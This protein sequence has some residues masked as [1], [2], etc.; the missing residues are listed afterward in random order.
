MIVMGFLEPVFARIPG[1]AFADA[2]RSL[3]ARR[4]G[5]A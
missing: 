4:L 1:E 2:V 3:A 5:G